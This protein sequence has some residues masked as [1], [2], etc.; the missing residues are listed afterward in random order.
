MHKK[1]K[2]IVPALPV[3]CD[4]CDSGD[5]GHSPVALAALRVHRQVHAD[6]P[7]ARRRIVLFEPMGAR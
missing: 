6:W 3:L 5:A 1:K 2:S 4:R 7:T